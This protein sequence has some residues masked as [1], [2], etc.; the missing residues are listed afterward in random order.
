MMNIDVNALKKITINNTSTAIAGLILFACTLAITSGLTI[1]FPIAL[2]YPINVILPIMLAAYFRDQEFAVSK[3]VVLAIGGIFVLMTIRDYFPVPWFTALVV[4]LLRI[5]IL[6]AV[7]EDFR[8][9]YMLN[10]V[11]GLILTLTTYFIDAYWHDYYYTMTSTSLIVWLIA[12]TL[13]NYRFVLNQY[14]SGISLFHVGV[15]LSPLVIIAVMGNP[16]LWFI[17]RGVTL[18]QACM[19]QVIAEDRQFFTSSINLPSYERL[20]KTLMTPFFCYLFFIS[21]LLLNALY[22]YLCVAA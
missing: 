19:V 8:T 17:G 12:Y 10:V 3:L 6:M 2:H 18:V 22:V 16:G 14:S 7:I 15:L 13:W 21:I 9:G 11:A 5:N 4:L 20:R 1:Y